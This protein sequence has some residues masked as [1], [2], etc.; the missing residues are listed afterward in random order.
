MRPLQGALSWVATSGRILI[1]NCVPDGSAIS[2]EAATSGISA[3]VLAL[4]R[5]A[6]LPITCQISGP[7]AVCA[8]YCRGK[9]GQGI[10]SLSPILA[11]A[12]TAVSIPVG[13]ATEGVRAAALLGVAALWVLA[14]ALV[15]LPAALL[16]ALWLAPLFWL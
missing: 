16:W 8:T 3:P 10:I 4:R 1:I 15:A 14:A 9:N 2:H 12:G 5:I 6:R 13:V 7:S 11:G